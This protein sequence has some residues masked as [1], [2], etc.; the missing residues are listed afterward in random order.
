MLTCRE[1]PCVR[2]LALT[3]LLCLA[4]TPVLA[5]DVAGSVEAGLQQ[6]AAEIA[7]KS[8]QADRNRIA[9]LPFPNADG[10]CSVLSNYIADELI[11]SLFS[12][13][14][15]NLQIV[16]RSQL[17][18]VFAELEMG[19]GG[20]LDPATTAKLGNMSGVQGLAVGTITSIG[21]RVRINARLVNTETG[22][23]ISAAAVTI[24]KT[25]DLEELLRQPV[26]TGPTCARK[27]APGDG[28]QI[29]GSA[30]DGLAFTDNG[31]RFKVEQVYRDESNN[32]IT[33][34]LSVKN[35]ASKET[36]LLFIGPLPTL[37]D[38]A[39]NER[40]LAAVTG[41][42]PHRDDWNDSAGTSGKDVS[43]MARLNPGDSLEAFLRFEGERAM[44]GW[45]ALNASVLRFDIKE[46]RTKV[47]VSITK[48]PL[49]QASTPATGQ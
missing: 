14:D 9:V 43:R 28:A 33:L 18:A 15:V 17:E 32:A 2:S 4:A 35:T 44:V 39:G 26:R 31:L 20:V 45:V 5:A 46:K 29:A 8:K 34:T 42:I 37:A 24:P 6:L 16:E 48:I 11:L 40:E 41:A 25:A 23:T 7:V 38:G 19:D 47:A 1:A 10:S 13:P 12:V 30:D 27:P 3:A 22:Q 21:D 36:R 49:G